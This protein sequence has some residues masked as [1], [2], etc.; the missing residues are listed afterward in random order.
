MKKIVVDSNIIP[1]S[2]RTKDSETRRK[3]IASSG[4]L[5]CSPNFLIA[6]LFK[7]RNRI[8]KNATASE[9]EILEFLN[10]ILEKIHF[11]NEEIISIEN[12]FEAYYLCRDIDPKDTSFIALTIELDAVLWT[13]DEILKRGL[14]A[15]GFNLFIEENDLIS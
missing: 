2:L 7:H 5:F 9:V 6:E 15:K 13:R 8:F 1:S 11:V 12:Y 3:L 4:V 10:Q 14:I